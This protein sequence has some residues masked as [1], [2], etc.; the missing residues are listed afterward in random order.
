LS[1]DNGLGEARALGVAA[2]TPIP[3]SLDVEPKA[4]E[5]KMAESLERRG[6]ATGVML[7]VDTPLLSDGG[8]SEEDDAADKVEWTS[9]LANCLP[10]DANAQPA[11]APAAPVAVLTRPA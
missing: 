1:V 2:R 8:A 6:E 5:A 10:I 4:G 11:N 9:L 7:A 3:G